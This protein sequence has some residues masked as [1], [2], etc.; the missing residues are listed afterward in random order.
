M[1]YT[2]FPF[3]YHNMLQ[4]CFFLAILFLSPVYA[5]CQAPAV[6]LKLKEGNIN[7]S[8][9]AGNRERS[10]TLYSTLP[11]TSPGAGVRIISKDNA[12]IVTESAVKYFGHECVITNKVQKTAYGLQ[13]DIYI[14]G[15]DS[16]WTVPIA[17]S[18]QWDKPDD[19]Q[20]WTSW[21]DNHLHPQSD[22][23]QD[24]FTYAPFQNLELN[25]GGENHLSRNAFV[26]PIATSF[27]KDANIGISFNE[28]LTDTILNLKMLTMPGGNISYR[29]MN[30]RIDGKHVIH[31]RHEIVFH[32]ADW[33]AGIGWLKEHYKEYFLPE[34]P[35]V[36]RIA[37]N[38]A[39]SSY[40]SEIDTAKYH[41][42]DF[43]INWKASLDFP[44]MGMFI[45][46]VKTSDERWLKYK[47]GGVTIGDGYATINRLNE[48]SKR[49]NKMGFYT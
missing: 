18:L 38:G 34:N 23:W 8:F 9:V 7:A 2:I 33:R 3:H 29:H 46:P 10:F 22:D 14:A 48:Y 26:I 45:P 37:G 6:Q 5:F 4:R 42:M 36:N 15:K 41:Q 25:Y 21:S 47:Q 20:F 30:Y 39:Y 44:Y 40:E 31:I 35:L 43:S 28:A 16:A 27:L 1:V 49:L 12:R 32:E 19:L 13:W 17:T 24:P 11:S